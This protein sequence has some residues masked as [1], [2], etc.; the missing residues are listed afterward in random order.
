MKTHI[1][2]LF[3]QSYLFT[4]LVMSVMAPLGESFISLTASSINVLD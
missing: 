4:P 1:W 3:V 2:D